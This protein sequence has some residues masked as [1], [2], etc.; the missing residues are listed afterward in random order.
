MCVF[1][2]FG[3]VRVEACKLEFCLGLKKGAHSTSIIQLT[4][5]FLRTCGLNFDSIS[6]VHETLKIVCVLERLETLGRPEGI[7]EG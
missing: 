1:S 7:A 2:S 4:R 6:Q 5:G 3:S